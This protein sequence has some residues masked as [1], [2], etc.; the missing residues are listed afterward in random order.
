M[1][2]QQ[3]IHALWDSAVAAYEK[4][5]KRKLETDRTIREIAT[6]D[7][8]LD[9]VEHQ[10][11]KF[12]GWRNRHAKLTSRLTTCLRPVALL[13]GIAKDALANTP[14]GPA[15]SAIFG[16]VLHLIQAADTVSEAYDWIERALAE[17]RE[18]TDRLNQYFQ[19]AMDFVLERK[20]TAVLTYVLKVLGRCEAL[21][22]RGRFRLYLRVMFLGKDEETRKMLDELNESLR[23]ETNYVV[24]ASFAS[25]K[26]TERAVKTVVQTT[27]E[28]QKGIEGVGQFLEESRAREI[29]KEEGELVQRSLELPAADRTLELFADFRSKLLRGTGN[30]L[31]QEALFTAWTE[32]KIPILWVFGGPGSGKSHLSTWTIKHLQE[33]YGDGHV[34]LG[35]VSV[36]YFYIR[37]NE[38]QL[39]D[40]NTILK[41]LAWQIAESDP[42][43]KE[44]AVKVCSLKKNIISAEDTWNRLFLD[45]YRSI[46]NVDRSS[47]LVIDGLDEA[48]RAARSTLLGLFKR[49][50]SEN[51]DGIR[52]RIQVA[53]IGRITLK[54][55]MD[56]EREEKFIQVSRE[57]NQDDL[58]RYVED[59][60]A[61]LSIIRKLV[62]LDKLEAKKGLEK[63]ASPR[64]PKVKDKLKE[65]ISSYA[66][67]VFLWAKL[68][69]DQ[70]QDKDIR[71]IEEILNR[72]PTTLK[73]MVKHV[74]ERLSAEEEDLEPIKKL[75]T[76]AAYAQR[77]LLFGEIDLILSLPS[78]APNL[79][80]WDKFRGKL[81]SI[82]D[83]ILPKHGVNDEYGASGQ[84]KDQVDQPPSDESASNTQEERSL[85][86]DS[87]QAEQ[88][89]TEDRHVAQDDL[90][91]SSECGSNE[92]DEHSDT[93]GFKLLDGLE[94][95]G[96]LGV[97]AAGDRANVV[98]EHLRAYADWQ[99]KTRIVFSH[100]QFREFLVFKR[101]RNPTDL[102][103]NIERSHVEIALTSFELLRLG[104]N[105][106]Q[107]SKY[108]MDYPC[109]FL[110]GHLELID[111]DAID[112]NDHYNI[113]RHLYW[114]FHDE[115][116]ARSLFNA[117]IDGESELWDDYWKTW[118]ATNTHTSTVR[119][120]LA[121]GIELGRCSDEAALSWMKAASASTTILFKT[122]IQTLA[123]MWL[124][125]SGFDDKAYCDKSESLVWLMHGLTSLDEHG[126]MTEPAL[127][128]FAFYQL[129][130]SRL[131]AGRLRELAN[132]A[133]DEMSPHW[134]TGLAWIHM[135]AEHYDEATYHFSEALALAPDAWV[136]KEGLA[137]IYGAQSRYGE[138]IQ[139]MEEA[140]SSLPEN[141][142]WLDGFLSPR[143]AEWKESIGDVQGA[144]EAAYQGFNAEPSS[145]IAQKSYLKAL[146]EK[147]DSSKFIEVLSY[148]QHHTW[149]DTP[150]SYLQRFFS[151]GWWYDIFDEVGRAF[152]AQNRPQFILE[153][154]QEAL[155]TVLAS[156]NPGMKVSFQGEAGMFRYQYNDDIDDTIRLLEQALKTLANARV[157]MQENAWVR[158]RYG[159]L[160]ARLYYDAGVSANENG[161]NA[162]PYTKRLKRMSTVTRIADEDFAESFA[163]YGPGYASMLW[164]C[165]LRNYEKA[166]EEMWNKAFRA[167]ILDEL[168]MLDDEDPSNDMAGLHSL[169]I[170]LLHVG[171]DGAAG[172]ILAVLFMPLKALRETIQQGHKSCDD[173]SND[174]QLDEEDNGDSHDV[175]GWEK[176]KAEGG[177]NPNAER[178]AH[179]GDGIGQG[180]ISSPQAEGDAVHGGANSNKNATSDSSSPPTPRTDQAEAVTINY[181]NRLALSLETSYIHACNGPCSSRNLEYTSL[182]ICR[183][184]LGT[185][186]CGECLQL[187]K[188]EKLGRRDCSPRHTWYQSWPIPDGK[189]E[190]AAERNGDRWIIRKEWLDGLREK[191]L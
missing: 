182:Y 22:T 162:W 65:R 152:R 144:Y 37:E 95:A 61:R 85:T 13:G 111:L 154:M 7:G 127:T 11:T 190:V 72:P 191:W 120:W 172:S 117:P 3:D 63:P 157:D 141:F 153:E 68:L 174:D 93:S 123:R 124:V 179:E 134:H 2:H 112:D 83:T 54:G 135:E 107:S 89:N 41:T 160:L 155:D 139:L 20:V 165:W 118:L 180:L 185:K 38:Q 18:F 40:T 137:R 166:P 21:I 70:I 133:L 130:F 104:P 8:L 73:S 129:D 9:L 17:L 181:K 176:T 164:G 62:E 145:S 84:T 183:I 69:L 92:S 6:V 50:L 51:A 142:A 45:F 67:G 79:L 96:E 136:A 169:A 33:V 80:L 29:T 100:L 4:E 99:T 146:D 105:L 88:N 94:T 10:S 119:T 86:Q 156:N 35:G 24:A 101:Q 148:M 175:Q 110:I 149:P 186:F 74:Y 90:D 76:W 167:R 102:D 52:S 28:N 39:R 43:F 188:E 71:E 158:G 57:K 44:H 30:W 163:F 81:S 64:A 184:C 106:Q 189:A 150:V 143:I 49:L 26:I 31:C 47:M 113:V 109:R 178:D 159:R 161:M 23:K 60:L 14:Y 1:D 128:D 82:F 140:R 87:E 5:T 187:V 147:G 122:W 55:D 12:S 36:A 97:L 27:A 78:K 77:P 75:L 116:G 131:S 56:F 121:A 177:V 125:K 138:A 16:A 15:S 48:P 66:D 114:L 58:D 170:T 34:Q 108:L 126:L 53:V 132:Y 19:I 59:R 171:D 46:A 25:V 103:I 168:N 115:T 151:S 32:Q 42:V 98:N 91:L 173:T